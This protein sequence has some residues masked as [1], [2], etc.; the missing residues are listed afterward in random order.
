MTETPRAGRNGVSGET[1]LSFLHRI[2]RLREEKAVFDDDEKQVFAEAKAAGFNVKGMRRVLKVRKMKP[3]EREE[4]DA[5][6]DLY[7]HAIGMA[8]ELPLFRSVG[9]MA[10][11]TAG[12]ES[13]VAALKQMVPENGEIVLTVAGQSMRLWRDDSGEAKMEEVKPRPAVDHDP[14]AQPSRLPER[15]RQE[16]PEVDD[17]GAK[18]LGRQAARDDVP[19]IRNP[20]PWDDS[21]RPLW[22][23]GWREIA[24][25]DGMGP[26]G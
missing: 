24:G 2:E 13:V 7:L 5:L 16:V 22:D 14:F 21:R 23:A 17:E 26:G 11:D 10:V 19:V 1:L 6:L 12:R 25:S 8:R 15:P 18:E 4:E 9:M 20:F 3:H